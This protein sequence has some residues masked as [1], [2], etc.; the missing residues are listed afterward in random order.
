VH[1]LPTGADTDR[2]TSWAQ[3]MRYRAFEQ[4]RERI[5]RAYTASAAYLERVRV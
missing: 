3:Y 1:L 4:T 2:A 5:E